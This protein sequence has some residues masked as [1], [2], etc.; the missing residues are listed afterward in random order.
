[1]NKKLMMFSIG[2]LLSILIMY[3]IPILIIYPNIIDTVVINSK[4]LSS[5]SEYVSA[6]KK[7]QENNLGNELNTVNKVIENS[8]KDQ[9]NTRN[10]IILFYAITLF[11]TLFIIGM[12]CIK[13]GDMLKFLGKGIICGTFVGAAGFTATILFSPS[14]FIL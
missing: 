14:Y 1:M 12:L 10:Y 5:N 6:V 7:I 2:Y 3:I 8:Y 4:Q 9:I 11:I 13:K